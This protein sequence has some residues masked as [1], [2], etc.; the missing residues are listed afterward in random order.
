MTETQLTRSDWLM[1]L[2]LGALTFGLGS[3]RMAPGVCGVYHD[4]AIYVSTAK[5]LAEGDGYRLIDVPGAPLQTKYPVVYPALLAA[6][7]RLWPAFPENLV[8]MQGMTLLTAAA[9][10]ALGYLYFV[11]FGYFSRAVSAGAGLICATA[12]TFLYFGVQTMAEMPFALLSIAAMWGVEHECGRTADCKM[13]D[14]SHPARRLRSALVGV[15]LALPFLCRTIGVT[16]IVAGIGVL[17]WNKRPLRWTMAGLLTLTLPWLMWSLAG[18]GNWEQSRVDGYYTDY[19]GCWS[20]TGLSM[21]G[22]VF[23]WNTVMIVRGSGEY[24]LE[25]LAAVSESHLGAGRT[26]ILTAS[27]GIVPWIAMATGLRQV[28]ILPWTLAAYLALML[29]WSWPPYRFL[30][31][32]LPWLAAYFLAAAAAA[33]SRLGLGIGWQRA[34]AAC[35]AVIAFAN[36]AL[37]MGHAEVV[38][39]TGYPLVDLADPQ[40]NWPAHQR[41]FAWL[42][43]NSRP[44]DVVTSGLD[45]MVALYTGRQAFRPIVY[46]PGQLFYGQAAAQSMDQEL[47]AILKLRRPRYLVQLPMP[48]FAEQQPFA[49][50][51]AELRRRNPEWLS[52]VYRDE[53]PRFV[54]YELQFPQPPSLDVVQAP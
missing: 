42:K 44:G 28:R 54:I 40:T 17:Y 4:D 21:F 8:L 31:P 1:A 39:Q 11:R 33:G 49:R 47:G 7:W 18:R 48:G 38:S 23:L 43:Q 35:L 50:A 15:L 46:Q 41:L 19:M 2:A 36:G 34:G 29:V 20:S 9:A 26:L 24:L 51:V 32:I 14:A 3:W 12:P 45:S 27:L 25:G 16:L 52:V 13:P 22:S 10:V 6:I 53:D 5:A 30:V 37:V